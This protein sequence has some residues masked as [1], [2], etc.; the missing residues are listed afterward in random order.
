MMWAVGGLGVREEVMGS[1]VGKQ[2][3]KNYFF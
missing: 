2:L 1:E 3:L